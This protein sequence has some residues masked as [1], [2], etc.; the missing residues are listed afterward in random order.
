MLQ[1]MGPQRVGHN[2]TVELNLV[3]RALVGE[4]NQGSPCL[5]NFPLVSGKRA[6]NRPF[7]LYPSLL[8][9]MVVYGRR[10]NRL[11]SRLGQVLSLPY[12]V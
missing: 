8:Q 1:V 6:Q 7:L 11:W 9:S 2:R 3:Y 5:E 12:S 4:W 10:D